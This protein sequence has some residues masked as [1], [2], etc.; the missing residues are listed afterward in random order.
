MNNRKNF[1]GQS[2]DDRN[3]NDNAPSR[4]SAPSANFKNILA[5]YANPYCSRC[6][7]TGYIGRFKQVCAGRCFKCIPEKIWEQMQEEFDRKCEIKTYC[8]EMDEIYLAVCGGDGGGPA[9]LSDGLW[10]TPDGQ[11]YD[12]ADGRGPSN[13]GVSSALRTACLNA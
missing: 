2:V 11:I 9:Y 8:D 13:E 5:G 12:V 10:I 6:G 1:T 4:Y 7:G 3:H